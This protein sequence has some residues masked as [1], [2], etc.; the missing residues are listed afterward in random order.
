MSIKALFILIFFP[1]PSLAQGIGL[2]KDVFHETVS[3]TSK[4]SGDIVMGVM[5]TDDSPSDLPPTVITGIPTFWKRPEKPVPVCVRIVSKDGRYEAENTYMVPPGF[6]IDSADFPYTGEHADF[7]ADRTAVALVVP[8]RCG[9]R[10]RTAVPTLW[11]ATPRTQNSVLHVYLNA[12]GNPS[13][14]AVGRGD[15]FFE[16][17]KDVSELTGLKYT[18]DCAIPTE[19]LPPD[20]NARL[21]F[22]ITRSNTEESFVLEVSP[23]RPRD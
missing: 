14:V 5:L 3:E 8:D 23:V 18:A 15:R 1:L 2:E 21:T 13:S 6:D 10:N 17:C 22:F 20:K 11:R 9:N 12:A 7:L 4:V 16:A 19:F